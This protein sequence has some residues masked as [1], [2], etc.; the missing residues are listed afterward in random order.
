MPSRPE[1]EFGAVRLLRVGDLVKHRFEIVDR[2]NLLFG[3]IVE[4]DVPE[5]H[6]EYFA[7]PAELLAIARN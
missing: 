6:D 2:A 4:L 5:Q 7:D 1:H 3:Q